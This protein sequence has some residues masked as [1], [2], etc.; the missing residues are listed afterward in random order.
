[1]EKEVPHARVPIPCMA[2][3]GGAAWARGGQCRIRFRRTLKSSGAPPAELARE[4]GRATGLLED[5][6]LRS[7]FRTFSTPSVTFPSS[8]SSSTS[9]SAAPPAWP[10]SSSSSTTPPFFSVLC[11]A[12][13]AARIRLREA[14]GVTSPSPSP[15]RSGLDRAED[16]A[17]RPPSEAEA[18]AEADDRV[19]R[20][21]VRVRDPL[22]D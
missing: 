11:L 8:S 2:S 9:S 1:M 22:R 18:E 4:A 17:D 14:F 12:R 19:R 20:R 6:A 5:D 15:S 10:S 7:S 21:L 13:L 3:L 16:R